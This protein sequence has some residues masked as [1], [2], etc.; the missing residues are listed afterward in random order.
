MEGDKAQGPDDI[1]DVI[2]EEEAKK[3]SPKR[4][5]MALKEFRED[6]LFDLMRNVEPF[7]M[8]EGKGPLASQDYYFIWNEKEFHLPPKTMFTEMTVY[9]QLP[10]I[11]EVVKYVVYKGDSEMAEGMVITE[12]GKVV[13]TL[14]YSVYWAR[15]GAE[16]FKFRN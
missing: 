1:Y 4:V 15:M 8:L 14:P 7:M 5:P 16:E 13:Q 12:S 9:C 6:D 10:G 3:E 2:Q 11:D